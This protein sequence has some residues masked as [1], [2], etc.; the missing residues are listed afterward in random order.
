MAEPFYVRINGSKDVAA[1]NTGVKDFQDRT[2][3]AAYNVALQAGDK[4]TCYDA[5]SGSAWNIN[6]LDPYGAYANFATGSDA[7]HCNVAGTY[8]IFIKMKMNDDIWYIAAQRIR[9]GGEISIRTIRIQCTNIPR[10]TRT[11]I[12]RKSVV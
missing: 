2:Q 12:D 7:L 8:N 6:A 4:L 3:Y 11:R 9:T 10:S 1:V 5:G